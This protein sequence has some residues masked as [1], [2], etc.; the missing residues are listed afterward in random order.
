MSKR[1]ELS[2][3][4]VICTFNNAPSLRQT[5]ASVDGLRIPADVRCE[6]CL[7]N[8]NSS[9]DTQAVC[10]EY[11]KRSKIPAR[12]VF[13]G[14]QGLSHARNRGIATATGDF[15]IFTDDDVVVPENWIEQYALTLQEF[16]PQAVFG[17]IVPQ[18]G[19]PAP[20]FFRSELNPA[21]ALL[22]YGD[23]RFV[24]NN[25]SN[26]FFG[27]NFGCTKLLL[28]ELG[29]F[30]ARLGRTKGFLFVGEER[31]IFLQLMDRGARIVYDPAISV[32]HVIADKRKNKAYLRKYYRD[33]ADSHIYM[34]DLRATRLLLGM[35][36]YMLRELVTFFLLLLPRALLY[37]ISADFGR[38]FLLELR[39]R[40]LGR[41]TQ[42]YF[43]RASRRIGSSL[44]LKA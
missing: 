2:I 34:A 14:N 4:I 40:T 9:D 27:A 8:N 1:R 38:M 36:L 15:L 17:R 44:G 33:I 24:V 25:R 13:E 23:S 3:S 5:L 26:E 43:K 19:G 39:A 12:A 11:V 7:V 10:E 37:T 30:D 35:P 6:L 18:W 20:A 29:G 31:Q 28:Q 21:Y 16:Q 42:A 22:D 41:M 32:Q